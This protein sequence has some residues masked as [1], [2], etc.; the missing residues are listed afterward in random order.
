[1]PDNENSHD[2]QT[3][4]MN[5][6]AMTKIKLELG[7]LLLILNNIKKKQLGHIHTFEHNQRHAKETRGKSITRIE[8]KQTSQI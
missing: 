1:M 4:G 8:T 7:K 6:I 2:R 5:Q 3:T